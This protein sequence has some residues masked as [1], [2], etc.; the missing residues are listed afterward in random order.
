MKALRFLAN[1]SPVA[2]AHDIDRWMCAQR[3]VSAELKRQVGGITV[4]EFDVLIH[5]MSANFSLNGERMNDHVHLPHGA[6]LELGDTAKYVLIPLTFTASY[7]RRNLIGSV[8]LFA[9]ATMVHVG[10][11]VLTWYT[12]LPTFG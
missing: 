6:R 3:E 9:L 4:G 11:G 8:V 10:C 7:V 12:K 2:L 5:D 1:D